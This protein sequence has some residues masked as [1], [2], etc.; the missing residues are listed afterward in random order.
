[1]TTGDWAQSVIGALGL[2]ATLAVA[3]MVYR[4][5]KRDQEKIQNT[6]Q[7]QAE[8]KR[9][10]ESDRYQRGLRR[11]QHLD[12]YKRATQALNVLQKICEEAD[13]KYL[14]GQQLTEMDFKRAREDIYDIGKRVPTLQSALD[15]VYYTSGMLDMYEMP[16]QTSFAYAWD[17]SGAKSLDNLY[18]TLQEIAGN[19][20]RQYHAARGGLGAIQQA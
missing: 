2:L 13:H 7:D 20:A 17:T 15:Q 3:L 11:E 16:S 4:L 18:E 19:A 12:D 14:N 6:A 10:E 8:L 9:K 5:Q 1:M